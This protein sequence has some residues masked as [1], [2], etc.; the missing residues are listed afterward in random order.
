M[1]R[2]PRAPAIA[3]SKGKT[4]AQLEADARKALES[5]IAYWPEVALDLL[6]AYAKLYA[7]TEGLRQL[8]LFTP[9]RSSPEPRY[10]LTPEGRAAL[11]AARNKP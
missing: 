11:A 2:K 8:E 7:E 6:K 3:L 4:A 1:S 9:P 5:G 10:T